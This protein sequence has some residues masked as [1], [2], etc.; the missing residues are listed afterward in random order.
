MGLPAKD[1]QQDVLLALGLL[2]VSPV[3]QDMIIFLPQMVSVTLNVEPTSIGAVRPVQ[4]VLQTNMLME[5]LAW[6]AQQDAQRVLELLHVSLANLDMI[7]FLLQTAYV[8]LSVELNNIEVGQA[9]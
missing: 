6:V 5:R 3:Y 9:A 7:I 4:L 1:A 8:I 2:L